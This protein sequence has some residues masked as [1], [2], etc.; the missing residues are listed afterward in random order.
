MTDMDSLGA[1]F[2]ALQ[3]E[4][5]ALRAS[6]VREVVTASD[7]SGSVAATLDESGQLSAL[8]VDRSWKSAVR[9]DRLGAACEAAIVAAVAARRELWAQNAERARAGFASASAF[10]Q[11]AAW[12]PTQTQPTRDLSDLT[13]F[14]EFDASRQLVDPPA[15]RL[16]AEAAV[17]AGPIALTGT[18]DG[19]IEVAIDIRWLS[20]SSA[21]RVNQQLEQAVA[22]FRTGLADV[23][24]PD[25]YAG[26]K[27]YNGQLD[28]A[29][30]DALA[31]LTNLGRPQ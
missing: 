7:A 26:F 6:E 15:E 13:P 2:G 11:P 8:V 17:A 19:R 23:E 25:P 12:T 30:G 16:P 9:P 10:G 20:E 3:A 22:T 14:V 31:H 18:A 24:Q 21:A 28:A 4:M 5:A 1:A 29:F 27:A